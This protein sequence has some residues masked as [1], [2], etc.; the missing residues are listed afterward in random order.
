MCC[1]LNLMAK[2]FHR[3]GYYI[4][5][6]IIMMLAQCYAEDVPSCLAHSVPSSPRTGLAGACDPT[7]KCHEVSFGDDRSCLSS[8]IAWRTP[9]SQVHCCMRCC[10]WYWQRELGLDTIHDDWTHELKERGIPNADGVKKHGWPLWD[11]VIFSH[12]TPFAWASTRRI[13]PAFTGGTDLQRVPF[14]KSLEVPKK[15]DQLPHH[16]CCSLAF[17]SS[18]SY[19]H[20]PRLPDE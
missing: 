3:R 14:E 11:D 18:F 19:G 8:P 15:I 10:L 16:L 7:R 17:C 6:I 1:L 5:I 4:I 13:S 20:T 9:Y 12:M 2:H